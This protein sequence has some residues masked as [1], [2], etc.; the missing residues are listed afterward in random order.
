MSWMD[1]GVLLFSDKRKWD[2]IRTIPLTNAKM[3]TKKKWTDGWPASNLIA[4][5]VIKKKT[6]QYVTLPLSIDVDKNL[7]KTC[8]WS[9]PTS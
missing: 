8:E 9:D 7:V 2:L 4:E 1:L 5:K 6:K 3:S